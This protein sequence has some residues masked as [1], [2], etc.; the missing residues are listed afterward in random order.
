MCVTRSSHLLS[1]AEAQFLRELL[2][3]EVMQPTMTRPR[4]PDLHD[5]PLLRFD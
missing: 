1:V 3:V 4:D 5:V 2:I